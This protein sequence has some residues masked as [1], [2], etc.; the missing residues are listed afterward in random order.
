[1]EGSPS[2]KCPLANHLF[3]QLIYFE[4]NPNYHW[5][6]KGSWIEGTGGYYWHPKEE[7]HPAIPV[8]Y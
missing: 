4:I 5:E 1:M 8:S 3:G 2:E 6:E 7:P